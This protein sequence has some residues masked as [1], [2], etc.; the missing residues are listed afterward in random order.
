MK[1]LAILALVALLLGSVAAPVAAQAQANETATTTE[2]PANE[3]DAVVYVDDV[4]KVTDYSYDAEREMFRVVLENE[5]DTTRQVTITE[6]IQARD[7]ASGSMGVQMLSLSPGERTV[8]VPVT[9]TD[10]SAAV[11]IVTRQSLE[12]GEGTF[13]RVGDDLPSI[14][15]GD[16]TWGYV[17]LGGLGGAGGVIILAILL[18]WH[19]VADSND[20]VEVRV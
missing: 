6:V 2:A 20:S 14:F 12:R 17:R 10:G 13:L 19:R 8:E 9:K 15:S 4:V 11:M 1:R 5:G 16:A 18:G 7:E 3:S